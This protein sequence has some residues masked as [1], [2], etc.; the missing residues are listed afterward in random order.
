LAVSRNRP[1]VPYGANFYS[2]RNS[3]RLGIWY[4]GPSVRWVHWLLTESK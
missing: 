1:S 3:A 4:S 2:A